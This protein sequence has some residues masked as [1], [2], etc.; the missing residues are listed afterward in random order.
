MYSSGLKTYQLKT[1]VMWTQL[2]I[3]LSLVTVNFDS[4]YKTKKTGVDMQE[5]RRVHLSINRSLHV[6]T[7][8][9]S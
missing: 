1:N 3:A 5:K 7:Y 9:K 8:N 6:L 4:D 2:E